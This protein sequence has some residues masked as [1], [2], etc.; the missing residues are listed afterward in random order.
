RAHDPAHNPGEELSQVAL[1]T[2]EGYFRSHPLPQ[3]RIAAV[4][5]EV[6]GAKTPLPRPLQFQDVFLREQAVH[7]LAD[8][9]YGTASTLATRVLA[10][11]PEDV[12]ALKTLA[13][14]RFA[15]R[16]Y[17]GAQEN[18]R[19]L[20][21]LDAVAA[22]DV[23]EF[24]V[25]LASAALQKQDLKAAAEIAQ[26]ALEFEPVSLE[27]YLVRIRALLMSGD[28]EA[29]WETTQQFMKI[30]P[31]G[32]G[33]LP[34]IAMTR[35]EELMKKHDYAQAERLA[36]YPLR[37]LPDNVDYLPT[38]ARA[39]FAAGDFAHAADAFLKV[40]E[41]LPVESANPA[42]RD[43]WAQALRAA[44]DAFAASGDTKRGIAALEAVRARL[45]THDA[46]RDAELDEELAGL[47]LFAGDEKQAKHYAD[48]IRGN[49]WTDIPFVGLDRI[50]WWY[51]RVGRAP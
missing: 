2:L 47:R 22:S 23:R 15:L 8:G 25:R 27:A 28:V 14:A 40:F 17:A 12:A 30:A 18:Y 9:R 1:E 34:Y 33:E 44:T 21:P 11:K 48:Y 6:G 35:A 16:D 7:A 49:K 51:Y 32:Q 26:R 50:G 20:V 42:R 38:Y 10:T 5:R 45:K 29:A 46:A 41:R 39:A 3:E 4:Q 36:E 13:E 37:I 19:K 24:A 31:G 43:S